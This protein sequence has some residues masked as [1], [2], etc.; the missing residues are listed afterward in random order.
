VNI[1][2]FTL[3]VLVTLNMRENSG[4]IVILIYA[5]T[6]VCITV[7]YRCGLLLQTE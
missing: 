3:V 1:N 7:L 2:V 5:W 4:F 6:R